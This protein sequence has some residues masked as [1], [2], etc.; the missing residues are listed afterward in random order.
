MSSP[1]APPE[2]GAAERIGQAG[3]QSAFWVPLLICTWLALSPSQPAAVSAFSAAVLNALASLG[4]APGPPE[5]LQGAGDV[6]LHALA[7]SYLTFALGL[8]LPG[9]GLVLVA[10]CMLAYG[11]FLEL[12]QSLLPT[13]TAE[14][15]DLLVD[16]A[17]IAAGMLL[18][19]TVGNACRRGV[20]ALAARLARFMRG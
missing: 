18:L 16:L 3:L 9:A 2:P 15:K 5:T 10:A 7:F 13:R 17:G 19:L 14:L 4:L 12:A 20:H 1:V 6:V 8:A 11:G